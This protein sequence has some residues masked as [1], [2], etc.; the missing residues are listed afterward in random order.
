MSPPST[1]ILIN[2]TLP[3]YFEAS[4]FP[5]TTSKNLSSAVT[6]P[7]S[8]AWADLNQSAFDF[9][10]DYVTTPNAAMLQS[11]ICTTLKDDV[12]MED[13]TTNEFQNFIAGLTGHESSLLVLSGTM[14]NQVAL[15]AALESP[16]Y[17]IVCDSRS[18]ILNMEAGGAATLSGALMIGVTPS[19]GHHLTLEDIKRHCVLRQDVYDCPTRVIS[20]ENTLSGTIMPLEDVRIIS[21][22]AHRQNPPIHMHLDGARLWEAV[23]AKAG[24]LKEY[25]TLFD[26]LSLCFTKGLGAPIGSIVV[27]NETFIR[28]ARW[29]RKMIGGGLRQAGVIA[30]PARVAVEEIFLKNRLQ[31]CQGRAKELSK[32]WTDLGGR[33]EHPTETN[34]ICG[35]CDSRSILPGTK[36]LSPDT[37]IRDPGFYR[38][39]TCLRKSLDR[40]RDIE[41][42]INASGKS[43]AT[44]NSSQ[45]EFSISGDFY[46][47]ITSV[48]EAVSL[49]NM[50]IERQSPAKT[51]TS[52]MSVCDTELVTITRPQLVATTSVFHDCKR[53]PSPAPF[54]DAECD[55]ADVRRTE[56]E[57]APVDGGPA[58]WKLLCAAFIFEALLWGFPLSF[59]VFQE[60]YSKV[61]EFAGNRYVSVVGTIASGFGYL[62][63]PVVMPFIQRHQRW[64]RRMIWIGWSI[65]IAALAFGSFASTLEVLILTQGVAYGIG[66][67]IF[68]YP[69]L[70][71][72]NEYWIARRGMAYGVLC[73]ASGV[74][75]SVMPFVLQTLLSRA[76]HSFLKRPLATL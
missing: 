64:R 42:Q 3:S 70:S 58:A 17:S 76:L 48:A 31:I 62:G 55:P 35:G 49:R 37:V 46:V 50:Q 2:D 72:V 54:Q 18:H 4:G 25:A 39:D 61:P 56:Q 20:L 30:A 74:S 63:A 51:K 10:S 57:L 15:R 5:N 45:D 47:L 28:R 68:Y 9:R 16:P 29:M 1:D 12:M 13:S 26:S 53:T 24:T 6:I 8:I 32:A 59:G 33:L 27:G 75:G 21:E 67:L 23:A 11:I 34:M 14:G 66:F 52:A 36:L 73:G 19:N 38:E 43:D 69:I 60:Y 71:M 65:C 41:C 22:W 7:S 44:A 40:A